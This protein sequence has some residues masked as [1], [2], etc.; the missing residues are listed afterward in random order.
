METVVGTVIQELKEELSDDTVNTVKEPS[1]FVRVCRVKKQC[2]I[3]L[4]L[5]FVATLLIC[6]TALKELLRDDDTGK[7]IGQVLELVSKVYFPNVELNVTEA[8]ASMQ[9]E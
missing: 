4:I 3:S 5:G 8:L 6:Y 1:A 2:F 7:I 9:K